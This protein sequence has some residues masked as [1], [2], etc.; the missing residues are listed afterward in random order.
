MAGIWVRDKFG[1]FHIGIKPLLTMLPFF[2]FPQI[3]VKLLGNFYRYVHNFKLAICD[4]VIGQTIFSGV[5]YWWY[6]NRAKIFHCF[7]ATLQ[8]FFFFWPTRDVLD[9][10][11]NIPWK[12]QVNPTS[13]L[14]WEKKLHGKFDK[15]AYKTKS[16]H[17]CSNNGN[18]NIICID[19]IS[20]WFSGRL[21]ISG[22]FPNSCRLIRPSL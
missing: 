12:V 3:G 8:L 14:K 2:F 19:A 9:I 18:Y 20:Y 13:L 6:Q 5:L 1:P 7:D 17:L 15:I 11:T 16:V 21:E 22:T 10:S 4:S